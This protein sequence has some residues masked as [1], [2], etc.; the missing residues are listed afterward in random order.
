MEQQKPQKRRD[1]ADRQR[2]RPSAKEAAKQHRNVHGTE[3]LADL[4]NLPRQKR[5]IQ[6][7][8]KAQRRVN[9]AAQKL[10]HKTKPSK[11]KK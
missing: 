2:I 3:R 8:R 1:K 9:Q 10:F 4:R 7:E 6:A 11:N 5:Q